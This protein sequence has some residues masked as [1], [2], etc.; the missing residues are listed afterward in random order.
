MIT[1]LSKGRRTAVMALMMVLLGS[2][3]MVSRASAANPAPVMVFYL[4][5]PENDMLPAMQ[6]INSAASSPMVTKISV[7]IRYDGTLVYYDHWEN[8]FVNDIANP[9]AGQTYANP[10]NLGG[11]QIW[12]NGL[13]ADGC[14]PALQTGPITCTNANDVLNSGD[15]IILEDNNVAVPNSASSI[16][17]DGKDKVAASRAIA[18]SRSLWASTSNSLFAWAIAMYPTSEWGQVYTAPVGCNTSNAGDMFEY[19]AFS[20][21]AAYDGTV[22]E[23][24][25][26]GNGTWESQVTL[27]E[28]ETYF[29]SSSSGGG[30]AYVRQGG[31]VRSTDPAKPIQ[32]VL[33]T[34]DIGSNY[35]SRDVN[36]FP[37]ASLSS[38]YLIP[39][40]ND[41]GGDTR[42]FIY[43]PEST[44]LYV[45][46]EKPGNSSVQTIAPGAVGSSFEITNDQAAHC[47]AVTDASGTTPDTSRKFTGL[48]T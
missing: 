23:V 20:I 35:A 1:N 39:I 42:L 22:I 37:D 15:V 16:D 4:T 48:A 45:K 28:G 41:N 21:T 25:P 14:A 34:G 6:V 11:V 30:C 38:S 12:G 31:K 5:E 9:T 32:V 36:L 33:V 8:G 10:G 47:Y 13:A 18:V 26:E 24:D 7:T 3:F 19:T 40:G 27:N 44:T 29:D 46:C 2:I 17:W 43:N